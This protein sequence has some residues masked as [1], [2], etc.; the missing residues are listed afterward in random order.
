MD[1]HA[2]PQARNPLEWL[3]GPGATPAEIA[4]QGGVAVFG[5]LFAFASASPDWPTWKVAV[6]IVLAFDLAGGVVTTTTTSAKRWYHRPGQ[7]PRQH[8]GF[9]A[10]HVL[11]LA[12]V[13]WIFRPPFDATYFVVM[14]ALLLS[15]ATAVVFS[16][17]RIRRPVAAT[18][19]MVGLWVELARLGPT[20]GLEWF[21]PLFFFKLIVGHLLPEEAGFFRRD[22]GPADPSADSSQRPASS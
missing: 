9:V 14:T 10:G 2:T 16:P 21:A 3:I 20:P 22:R 5:A 4:L 7:G 18:V 13:A 6:A 1:P 19:W 17:E 15:G 12:A 11:H 8:L